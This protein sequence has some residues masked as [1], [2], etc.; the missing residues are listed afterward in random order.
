VHGIVTTIVVIGLFVSLI[1]MAFRLGI[2]GNR[3]LVAVGV[4]VLLGTGGIA[5]SNA[6][7]SPE[8]KARDDAAEATMKANQAAGSDQ[9]EADPEN[10]IRV[11]T[12]HDANGDLRISGT[13]TN[14]SNF[15]IMNVRLRC[16][17]FGEVGGRLD[18][19]IITIT[20][21]VPANGQ[22]SFGPLSIGFPDQQMIGVRCQAVDGDIVYG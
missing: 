6:L 22:V 18:R 16:D 4:F 1:G 3:R 9:V 5:L 12:T 21:R 17:Q 11:E 8:Q 20:K 14:T 19:E 7:R 15:A 2:F 13:L 10:Y